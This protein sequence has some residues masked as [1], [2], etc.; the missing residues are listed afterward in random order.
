MIGFVF[1]LFQV[2]DIEFESYVHYIIFFQFESNLARTY[3]FTFSLLLI[4]YTS[5]NH[6]KP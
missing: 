2:F 1:D 3:L 6:N 5:I 4:N